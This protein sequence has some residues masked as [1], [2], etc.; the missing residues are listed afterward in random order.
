M[1]NPEEVGR[2]EEAP[3]QTEGGGA[4]QVGWARQQGVTVGPAEVTGRARS[5]RVPP[6]PTREGGHQPLES[7]GCQPPYQ[8]RATGQE[9]PGSPAPRRCQKH[10]RLKPRAA[11]DSLTGTVSRLAVTPVTKTAP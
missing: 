3:R 7:L 1:E 8:S 11:G 9:G 5:G 4:G 2:K 6:K 10:L